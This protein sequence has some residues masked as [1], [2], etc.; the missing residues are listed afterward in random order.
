VQSQPAIA[1]FCFGAL[2]QE[3]AA[4]PASCV[5]GPAGAGALLA[6]SLSQ[7]QTD[8]PGSPWIGFV[9]WRTLAARELADAWEIKRLWVRPEGRG[10]GA[11][12]GL[13]ETIIQRARAAGKSRLLLDTAPQSMAAAHQ[14]YLDL[15]FEPCPPYIGLAAPGIEY[16]HMRL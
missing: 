9:A 13:V 11:G 16:M 3:V 14:L 4:L 12:R 10:T 5:P 1:T 8:R 15:G 6:R 7:E 2:E